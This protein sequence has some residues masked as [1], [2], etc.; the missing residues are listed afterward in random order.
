[1]VRRQWRRRNVPLIGLTG[2][3]GAG[4]TTVLEAFA[5]AGCATISTDEIVH[6][7][8]GDADVQAKLV[9]RWGDSVTENG[10]IA[11]DRV[12]EIVFQNSTEL[13][14]LEGVLFPLVGKRVI[15]WN[16]QDDAEVTTGLAVVEVPLLF[17]SGMEKMFNT[18]VCV[19]ADDEVREKRLQGRSQAS[20]AGREDRQLS[21]QEKAVKS[22]L[23]VENNG[24]IEDLRDKVRKLVVRL[25]ER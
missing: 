2:G 10:Q 22:D 25:S 3:I 18:T 7:L 11:R 14:W 20:L 6:G 17:E 9:N 5:E 13:D 15:E 19:V 23:V 12:A 24:S 16:E 1:M 8:L 21:Q 4:K